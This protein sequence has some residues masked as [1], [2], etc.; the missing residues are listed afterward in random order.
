MKK[1]KNRLPK[2]PDFLNVV[3]VCIEQGRY[4]SCLHLQQREIERDITRREVLYVLLH[5]FHEKKEDDFDEG[6]MVWHYAIR[7]KTL[8]NK[9]LRVF[10]SFDKES[11][12]VIITT[13]EIG[14]KKDEKKD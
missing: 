14:K 8:D 2:I 4:L 11:F 5:G 1:P 7:G 13:F 3:R 6:Y 10:I 12:M 9:D